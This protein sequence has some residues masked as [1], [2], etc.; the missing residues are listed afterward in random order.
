MMSFWQMAIILSSVVWGFLPVYGA[1]VPESL[2]DL[3]LQWL[4]EWQAK[5]RWGRD[6]FYRDRVAKKIGG[7]ESAE[8]QNEEELSL[9]A[10]IFR[11]GKGVAIINEQILRKGDSIG[12]GVISRIL[13]D[14]VL[15]REGGEVIV[16]RVKP[17]GA[18]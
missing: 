14:R 4:S 13:P 18:K 6:P 1:S 2:V 15:L 9:S 16:L 17:F 10:I 8:N 12:G 11:D 3:D 7:E 5:S